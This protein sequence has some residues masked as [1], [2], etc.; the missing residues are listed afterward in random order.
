ML[1]GIFSP[2]QKC[3]SEKF[4]QMTVDGVNIINTRVPAHGQ[5]L[6]YPLETWEAMM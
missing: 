6:L 2:I 4:V 5:I 1:K 3:A